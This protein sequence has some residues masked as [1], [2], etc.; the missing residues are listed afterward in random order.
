ME[1]FFFPFY[2]ISAIYTFLRFMKRLVRKPCFWCSAEFLI[3]ARQPE[4]LRSPLASGIW[5]FNLHPRFIPATPALDLAVLCSSVPPLAPN[6]IS[7]S[8]VKRESSSGLLRSAPFLPPPP[9][10]TSIAVTPES[11][12][13][14]LA[15]DSPRA[16]TSPHPRIER[17]VASTLGLISRRSLFVSLLIRTW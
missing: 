17:D 5:L 6:H 15:R 7:Q 12:V 11:S 8:L 16:I 9:F 10:H 14:E 13:P 2:L 4:T 1:G 3:P